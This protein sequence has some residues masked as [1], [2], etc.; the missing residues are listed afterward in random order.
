MTAYTAAKAAYSTPNF[1]TRSPRSTEYELIG[2][3]TQTLRRAIESKDQNYPAYVAALHDNRRLWV[4]L[5]TN[6]ADTANELPGD[7]RARLFY[8]SEFTLQ[9]T[10]AVLVGEGSAEVL[11][12]I[13]GAVMEGL[14]PGAR[15]A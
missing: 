10:R 2:R 8:L 14:Q 12:E 13:N 7:L 9:H 3:V 11:V 4:A 1:A 6:V 15:A 5:A